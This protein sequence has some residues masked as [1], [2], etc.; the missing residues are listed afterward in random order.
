M[1]LQIRLDPLNYGLPSGLVVAAQI[2][3]LYGGGRAA[4][5]RRGADQPDALFTVDRGAYP[6]QIAVPRHVAG[7]KVAVLTGR[8]VIE[9]KILL[10]I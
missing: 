2:T 6:L 4:V 3:H 9:G 1:R 8:L 10:R 7:V 5:F